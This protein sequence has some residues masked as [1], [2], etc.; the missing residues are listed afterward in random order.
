MA[1]GTRLIV[2]VHPSALLRIEDDTERHTAYRDFVADLKQAAASG[3]HQAVRR[4]AG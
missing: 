1:D 2:T 3:A 4:K